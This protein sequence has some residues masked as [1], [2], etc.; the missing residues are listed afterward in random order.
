MLS[1]V[2]IPRNAVVSQEGEEFLS[3][4]DK[5]PPVVVRKFGDK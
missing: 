3:I 2:V 5:P 1:I 4:S